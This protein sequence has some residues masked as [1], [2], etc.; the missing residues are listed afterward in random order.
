MSSEGLTNNPSPQL[1]VPPPSI[2][3]HP[4]TIVRPRE[5]RN[6]LDGLPVTDTLQQ[7]EQLHRQLKLLVR[8]P[9]IGSNF[10][11]LLSLY[12]PALQNLQNSVW[13]SLIGAGHSLTVP[14]PLR[15]IVSQLMLEIACGHMRLINERITAGK[16]PEADHVYHVMLPLCRL[17]HWDLLQYNLVRPSIW[18]QVLQ[19]YAIGDLYDSNG[20][21]HTGK[22]GLQE[23]ARTSH[24]VFFSTLV[25]LLCDPYRL[26][27]TQV[28]QLIKSLGKAAE[29][30]RISTTGEANYRIAVD[31][32]G[33]LPPLRY[34]RLHAQPESNE[35]YLQLDD[36]FL[37]YDRQGIPG[38]EAHL[39]QWLI[40]SLRDLALK[41]K[42]REARRHPRHKHDAGYRFE[43]GLGKIHKRLT[44]VQ[45]GA[46]HPSAQHAGTSTG[47]VLDDGRSSQSAEF[48]TP[49]RQLDYSIN[50]VGFML[51]SDNLAPSVGSWVLLEADKPGAG[52]PGKPIVG[53]VRRRLKFD[54]EGTEIGLEKLHGSVIPVTFGL[55]QKQA[56]FHDDRENHLLQVIAPA[57]TYSGPGEQSLKSHERDFT[58]IFEELLET[59]STDLIRVTLA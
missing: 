17:L 8:D 55:D 12:H 14:E 33:R 54:D 11:E 25:M 19:L 26:T 9:R 50:G 48:G 24:G 53:R 18:R 5:L 39:A 15:V 31:M 58:V 23:D 2:A 16:P 7:A 36:F 38:G 59:G 4:E 10:A 44:E 47:I 34:A 42:G 28:A 32:S 6:W 30:L 37:Q 40:G 51:S 13:M 3:R 29:H 21:Q 43:H 45:V 35:Q 56:L 46:Q 49:C 27:A 20:I 22:L 1:V 41:P 52:T 57:G